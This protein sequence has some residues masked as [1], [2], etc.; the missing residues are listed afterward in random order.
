MAC[1]EVLEI[2]YYKECL[3]SVLCHIEHE[4]VNCIHVGCVHFWCRKKSVAFDLKLDCSNYRAWLYIMSKI[5]GMKTFVLGFMQNNSSYITYFRMYY[6]NEK[7]Q[8]IQKLLQSIVISVV[9]SSTGFVLSL[10]C[11]CLKSCLAWKLLPCEHFV[12]SLQA[13]SLS[14]LN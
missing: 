5:L 12:S 9:S 3:S 11:I 6:H 14:L 13:N 8:V 1:T 4:V 2:I 10:N 7:Y